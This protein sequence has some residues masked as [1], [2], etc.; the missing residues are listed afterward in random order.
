MGRKTER[1]R[2]IGKS[3]TNRRRK[4]RI[5]IHAGFNH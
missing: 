4:R 1:E 3:A 5:G 2:E